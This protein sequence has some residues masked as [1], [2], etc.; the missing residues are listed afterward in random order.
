MKKNAGYKGAFGGGSYGSD[1][2]TNPPSSLKKLNEA[3]D[4]LSNANKGTDSDAIKIEIEN[5]NKIWASATEQMY[6]ESSSSKAENNESSNETT[7]NKSDIKDADFE[8][9]DDGAK[10]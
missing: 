1:A 10:K 8:V 9:V 7:D 5:L 6:K 3:K 4:K 2:F